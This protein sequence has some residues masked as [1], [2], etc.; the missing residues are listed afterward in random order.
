MTKV[1]NDRYP[2]WYAVDEEGFI[3]CVS[4]VEFEIDAYCLRRNK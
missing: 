2:L 3:C 4:M 1:K